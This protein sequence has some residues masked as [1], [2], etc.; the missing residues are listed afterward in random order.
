VSENVEGIVEQL[1]IG[2]EER[3]QN[4]GVSKQGSHYL[5]VTLP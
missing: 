3:L 5:F 2:K 1:L 4:S